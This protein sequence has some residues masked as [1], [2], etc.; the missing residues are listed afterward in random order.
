MPVKDYN[1]CTIIVG[2]A[3]CGKTTLARRLVAEHLREFPTGI[4]LIH[5]PVRQFVSDGA[6]WYDDV[7]TWRREMQRAA[8]A[9][10]AVPRASSFGGD[11][12]ALSILAMELGKRFRNSAN[13][14]H[15]P[16]LLVFDEGSLHDERTHISDANNEL[17]A[18]RRHLGVGMLFLIQRPGMLVNAFWEGATD[19]YIFKLRDKHV[20]RLADSLDVD[21]STVAAAT[22]LQKYRHVHV[23][24]GQASD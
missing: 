21:V 13:A 18:T 12:R 11:P 1:R 2:A 6:G 10:Q 22:R 4:V 17:I 3:S 14:V 23:L 15:V 9:K 24:Q 8:A 16:I 19:A 5:D 20:E 7:A